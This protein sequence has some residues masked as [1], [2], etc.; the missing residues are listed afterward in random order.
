MKVFTIYKTTV[1][2]LRIVAVG[3]FIQWQQEPNSHSSPLMEWPHLTERRLVSF[4]ESVFSLSD[5]CSWSEFHSPTRDILAPYPEKKPDGTTSTVLEYEVFQ[6]PTVCARGVQSHGE[7]TP[8]RPADT[9]SAGPAGTRCLMITAA[10]DF[11]NHF[12]EVELSPRRLFRMRR[13]LQVP[14]CIRKRGWYQTTETGNL[15]HTSSFWKIPAERDF[16]KKCKNVMH[17]LQAAF[18]TM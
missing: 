5:L 2:T 7:L 13:R 17:W 10:S 6:A 12:W 3:T 1:N 16:W 15:K 14:V 9:R 18:M 8:Q 4:S 11:N